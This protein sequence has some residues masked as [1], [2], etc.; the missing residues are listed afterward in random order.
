MSWKVVLRGGNI[1]E[2]SDE[3]FE[4]MLA[5]VYRCI[6]AVPQQQLIRNESSR[7]LNLFLHNFYTDLQQVSS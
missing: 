7:L 3:M 2:I 1:S 5:T 4:Q 6:V